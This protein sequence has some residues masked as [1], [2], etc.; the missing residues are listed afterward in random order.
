MRNC[1][2]I[3]TFLFLASFHING[4]YTWL[5]PRPQGNR[6]QEVFALDS[7]TCWAAGNYG[8]IMKT[9][10]G[11]ETWLV[12][13]TG[14]TGNF[15][16]ICFTD[17]LNGWACIDAGKIFHTTDGGSS[18]EMNYEIEDCVLL[19]LVFTDPLHGCAVGGME[20]SYISVI[21]MTWDGGETWWRK[22]IPDGGK[23]SDVCFSDFN[24]GW[25]VSITGMIYRTY[26][27][28]VNWSLV[29][30]DGPFIWFEM[31][32]FADQ[33]NGW[34][35]D[36]HDGKI[37]ITHDGGSNW[38]IKDPNYSFFDLCYVN[39]TIGYSCGERFLNNGPDG[40]VRKSVNGGN[41]W[42]NTAAFDMNYPSALEFI[43]TLTGWV[44]G[45][46]GAI[47]KTANG[48]ESWTQQTI[49]FTNEHLSDC[50]FFNEGQIGWVTGGYGTLLYTR[51]FGVTW[52]M[53]SSGLTKGIGPV[54]FIDTLN[55]W[56]CGS[57]GS[58]LHTVDG[59]NVWEKLSFP[60]TA[61]CVDIAFP[62]SNRGTILCDSGIVCVTN[63]GG[64][65]WM[66]SDATWTI[67]WYAVFF[68][69]SL[70]GWKTGR[71]YDSDFPTFIARTVN[72]GT[73]WD[74]TYF[75]SW[76]GF[77]ALYFINELKGW[78]AGGDSLLARTVDGGVTWISQSCPYT[79]DLYAVYFK[80]EDNGVIS[81][82][83]GAML[84]TT[85][86]GLSYE[87]MVSGTNESLRELYVNSDGDIWAVGTNGCIITYPQILT[88]IEIPSF[89]PESSGLTIS[90]NPFSDQT[91]IS[92][93]LD[94]NENVV[95]NIYSITGVKIFTS[96]QGIQQK[97]THEF[98]FKNSNL[99]PGI[100]ICEVRATNQQ[101]SAKIVIASD[102]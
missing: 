50:E 74:T 49:E 25:T 21:L 67:D 88:G 65:S 9:D 13:N 75:D 64:Q 54:D 20:N 46:S 37:Y 4:Q 31:V 33:Y 76:G 93:E 14:T 70:H 80:D 19:G 63:D 86:G 23:L 17:P 32:S 34:A 24:H 53:Q 22:Q 55:G 92:Y 69:D 95:V 91:R 68:Y 36:T 45:S 98:L 85:N 42:F 43:D 6:L 29:L 102:R 7:L 71:N 38:T 47:F 61:Y 15:R 39:S 30:D 62:K 101:F 97:G 35:G 82:Y 94:M 96:Y 27:G 40:F 99:G 18:W 73:S 56:A 81:G 41:S 26:N 59:G 52:E 2:L 89:S 11:G 77:K 78:A 16:S 57:E 12:Q 79:S 5:N 51:D 72:G 84:V 3:F 66:K 83:Q 90:P 48:G 58:V 60:T 8:T 44:V 28:G 87:P 10:D 100:Y 1:I